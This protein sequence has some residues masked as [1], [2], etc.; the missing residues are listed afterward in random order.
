MVYYRLYHL[1]GAKSEVES[2]REFEA[3][4]DSSAIAQ[5]ETWRSINPMELW[6]GHRKVRRW[7]S[8]SQSASA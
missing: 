2:F 5:S 4:D 6:S 7:E 8:I 1:R 3:E